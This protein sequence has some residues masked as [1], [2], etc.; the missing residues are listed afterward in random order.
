MKR[1]KQVIMTLAL[2]MVGTTGVMAQVSGS[3]EDAGRK[4]TYT[5]SGGRLVSLG[6]AHHGGRQRGATFEVKAGEAISFNCKGTKDGKAAAC[7][8]NAWA[9]THPTS[10]IDGE[11]FDKKKISEPSVSYTYTVPRKAKQVKL[12][13]TLYITGEKVPLVFSVRFKVVDNYTVQPST[14][15]PAQPEQ[16]VRQCTGTVEGAELKMQYAMS[17]EEGGKITNKS[18]Y[19]DNDGNPAGVDIG[20]YFRTNPYYGPDIEGVVAEQSK[21]TVSCKK[22]Q[23]PNDCNDVGIVVRLFDKTNKCISK[24]NVKQTKSIQY[25][26]PVTKGAATIRLELWYKGPGWR[27][28]DL[29]TTINLKVIQKPATTTRATQVNWTDV[30]KHDRCSV[31]HAQWS[32]YS[33]CMNLNYL[34]A[35]QTPVGDGYLLKA[36]HACWNHLNGAGQ[37]I[38]NTHSTWWDRIY[39]NEMFR[40]MRGS[41]LPLNYR[42]EKAT[43]ILGDLEGPS[44]GKSTEVLL[45]KRLPNGSDRWVVYQGKITGKYLKHT[46][47]R[48]SFEMSNCEADPK[49]TIFILE[50][51]GNTSRVYLLSGS[52]DVTSKKTKK[53]QTLQPGQFSTVA[54]DGIIKVQTFDINKMAKEN[55][56][57]TSELAGKPT[58]DNRYQVNCAVVKYKVTKGNQQGSLTK[59]FDNYGMLERRELKMGNQTTILINDRMVCYILDPKK[60]TAKITDYGELNFLDFNSPQMQ[61]LK[62]QEKGKR[63]FLDKECTIYANSNTEY[64]VWKGVVLKK[65]ERT[66]NGTTTTEATSVELPASVDA[67]YFKL[68]AGYTVK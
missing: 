31:C 49:G 14:T 56:I 10:T 50:D 22:L 3:L 41:I 7:S 64:Y 40:V 13:A 4:L 9:S 2:L 33:V 39:Y 27:R 59:Y 37:P 46:G 17:L 51:D 63:F 43:L 65:V 20:W 1:T 25:T 16:V 18:N 66:S 6:E 38:S 23:G 62:L 61:K 60:R 30:D 15:P 53:K 28:Y 26:I 5:V 35:T 54:K 47:N 19:T 29:R 12:E 58:S 8:F 44:Y 57:T 48:P 42:D 32:Y 68:P 21:I 36:S 55:S 24:K 34:S 67:K 45:Q 52:M 11:Q